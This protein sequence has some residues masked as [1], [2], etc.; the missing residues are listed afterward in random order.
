MDEM[1]ERLFSRIDW[2][3]M[4][5]YPEISGYYIMV[6]DTG[7]D[8]ATQDMPIDGGVVPPTTEEPVAE[9]HRIGDD[10]KVVA[11]LPGITEQELRLDVKGN[12]LIIDAG[13]A[14]HHYHTS[15]VLPPVDAV[16]MQHSLRNGVLEVTFTAQNG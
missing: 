5:G 15:A 3:F 11:G 8:L 4:A 10:V 9:V 16:S 2:E 7:E 13:D 1:F 6:R 14:D 12:T